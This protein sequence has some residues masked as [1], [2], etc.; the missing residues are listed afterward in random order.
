MASPPDADGDG[1]VPIGFTG[2]NFAGG[3]TVVGYEDTIL[4]SYINDNS[5]TY[6]V[7]NEEYEYDINSKRLNIRIP[8]GS[9]VSK[10]VVCA[11]PKGCYP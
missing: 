1:Q 9:I 8:K 7:T 2:E 6:V 10:L 11:E 5:Q 3:N 4:Y